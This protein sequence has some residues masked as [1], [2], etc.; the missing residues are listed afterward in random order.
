MAEEAIALA[1]RRG[2]RA[3]E[4]EEMGAP[5]PAEQVAREL[6]G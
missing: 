5:I 6:A 2:T 1:R 3:F 4:I